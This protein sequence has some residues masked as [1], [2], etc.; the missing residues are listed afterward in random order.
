MYLQEVITEE[1]R[2]KKAKS[3]SLMSRGWPSIKRKA[4][5]MYSEAQESK[6]F[7]F[8]GTGYVLFEAQLMGENDGLALLAYTSVETRRTVCE[9][10]S[11]SDEREGNKNP[12]VKSMKNRASQY[13]SLQIGE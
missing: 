7:P 11:Y 13:K 10:K 2:M 5:S 8:S 9:L 1:S 4:K 3:T 12:H 6:S